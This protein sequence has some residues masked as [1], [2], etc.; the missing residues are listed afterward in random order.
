MKTQPLLCNQA[1]QIDLVNYLEKLGHRAQKIRG[2]DY[3]YLSPLRDEKTPSFKV[4]RKMNVWYDHA[5]GKGG[6]LVDFGKL[7]FKC[8]VKELLSKL[9]EEKA[10]IVSFHPLSYQPAGEKKELYKQ[11]GKIHV[12]TAHLAGIIRIDWHCT[13]R[14]FII[15]FRQESI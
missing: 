6:T 14:Q 11:A 1:N 8:S 12:L 10:N 7:Y 13:Y 15:I 9:E 5:M 3:W 2:N 4:N